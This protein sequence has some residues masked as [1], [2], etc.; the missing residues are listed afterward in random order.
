MKNLSKQIEFILKQEL[1]TINKKINGS[2]LLEILKYKLID[3]LYEEIQETKLENLENQTFEI[4]YEDEY[5]GIDIKTKY[6]EMPKT[7]LNLKIQN[8]I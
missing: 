3:K 5:R 1:N 6:F 7:D 4:H 8:L 2:L